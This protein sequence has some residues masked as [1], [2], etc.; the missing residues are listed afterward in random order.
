MW[1]LQKQRESQILLL[2]N[3]DD[4]Q[5]KGTI[6]GKVFEYLA[7]MRPVLAI[8]GSEGD[9]IHRILTE[10]GAGHQA[11]NVESIKA[12]LKKWYFEYRS[13]GAVDSNGDMAKIA[14]HSQR[15][16]ARKFANIFSGRFS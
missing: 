1:A 11:A 8:G 3:W 10:T 5:E 16:M 2:L 7:A 6:P 12:W 4:P 14:R 9:V 13:R 15:E